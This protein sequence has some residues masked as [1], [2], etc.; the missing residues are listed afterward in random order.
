MI[1]VGTE[2]SQTLRLIYKKNGEIFE[3]E[4]FGCTFVKLIG[5]YGW[6]V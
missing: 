4:K 5:K 1:P 2:K 6:E 3:E